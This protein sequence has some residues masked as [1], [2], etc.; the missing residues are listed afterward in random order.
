MDESIDDFL[1]TIDELE[2][3]VQHLIYQSNLTSVEKQFILDH[4]LIIPG[5][6]ADHEESKAI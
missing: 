3:K 4:I 2:E 6:R 5:K 1:K